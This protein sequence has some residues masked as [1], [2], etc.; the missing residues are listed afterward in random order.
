MLN[1]HPVIG[2][3]PT[4]HSLGEVLPQ[5]KIA[6]NF[7]DNGGKVIF[8]SHGGQFEYLIKDIGCKLIRLKPLDYI[9]IIEKFDLSKIPVEKQQFLAYD[10]KTIELFVKDEI[11]AFKKTKIDLVLSSFNPTTS[12]SARFLKIPLVVLLSGT[13]TSLYYSS[14]YATFPDNYENIFTKV[15]PRILKRYITRW[16]LLNNK[17]F[18]KNFN[19]VGKKYNIKK[20][21]T[22]NEILEGDYTLVCDDINLLGVKPSDRFPL[23]NFIGPVSIGFSDYQSKEVDEDIIKHL[24]RPGKSIL[25]IMGSYPKKKRFINILNMLNKTNYNIVVVSTTISEKDLSY[26]KENIL[27]KK[28]IKSPQAINKMVDLAIIHGGR[29]TVYNAAYS[30]KP[31]IGIPSFI[32]QQ[33]NIDCLVRHG[34]GI[35][36]S[37]KFF[38]EDKL[39]KA[40]INIFN[41]YNIYLKN[42]K[43]LASKLQKEILEERA[44]MRINEILKTNNKQKS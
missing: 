30:G 34:A 39:K 13:S 41:N 11:E 6:K 33:Y 28:F 7:I 38:E 35:R 36:L 2:F 1:E 20:F 16:M 4:F 43:N 14:G 24:K 21:K 27:F 44:S 26:K 5:K 8:F 9:E 17:H 15:L 3:F 40:I 32:E 42:A 29:G 23:K 19:I 31:S 25:L 22:L 12:I 37:Y 18:V 10:K